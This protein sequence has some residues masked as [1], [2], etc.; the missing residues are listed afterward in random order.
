ML[1]SRKTDTKGR[2]FFYLVALIYEISV[3]WLRLRPDVRS[4][5]FHEIAHLQMRALHRIV[6]QAVISP[7]ASLQTASR[8]FP[9]SYR[10]CLGSM[11]L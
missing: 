1:I 6:R 9:L 8:P 4:L 11:L 3:L 5:H 10:E 7:V 2:G